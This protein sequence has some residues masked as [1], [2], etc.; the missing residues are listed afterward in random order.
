MTDPNTLNTATQKIADYILTLPEGEYSV[1]RQQINSICDLSL[2]NEDFSAVQWDNF[3]LL[4]T[5]QK[6]I[7]R[8]G[9]NK[10]NDDID[11]KIYYRKD[12]SGLLAKQNKLF[13]DRWGLSEK[14]FALDEFKIRLANECT[15][16]IEEFSS[17]ETYRNYF[18]L[19]ICK[20]KPIFL[21]ESNS[22]ISN[23][24]QFAKTIDQLAHILQTFFNVLST[25]MDIG[26]MVDLKL[27]ITKV[28]DLTSNPPFHLVTDVPKGEINLFKSGAALLD[29]NLVETSLNW[30]SKYPE[31]KRLF[32][33]ALSNY[34][35]FNQTDVE[36]RNIYDDLRA[37]LEKLICNILGNEKVLR[38]NKGPIEDWLKAKG[39]HSNVI[40]AFIHILHLY[41]EF[42][43]NVK[44]V[45][46]YKPDDLEYMIYQTAIMMRM[47]L[48]KER[49]YYDKS[50]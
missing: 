42:M 50:F 22:M 5:P 25:R 21:S 39:T 14:P 19:V 44:H 23:E 41:I 1:E 11:F 43:D 26:R 10:A 38:N 12:V 36:A 7:G 35:D 33:H 27:A 31:A 16:F 40:G 29:E 9:R 8:F 13:F 3:K 17:I 48:E 47:L 34:N 37:S 4:S 46:N 45:S 20:T 15:E 18:F 24:I 32:T 49:V 30:L 6:Q 2:T 28:L